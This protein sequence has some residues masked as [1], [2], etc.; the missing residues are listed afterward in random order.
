[1]RRLW[2]IFLLLFSIC[3][4]GRAQVL[5]TEGNDFWLAFL[6]NHQPGELAL[7]ISGNQ[8]TTGSVVSSDSSWSQTFSVV[9]GS[10]TRIVVPST[11]M[12]GDRLSGSEN[13]RIIYGGEIES[14][15][16]FHVTT[17]ANVS[18]YA[19]NYLSA[20]YDITNVLPTATLGQ[21]YVL[22]TVPQTVRSDYED[23]SLH[24]VFG[25]V[26]TEDSTEV[27]FEVVY[28][29]SMV[30][31][32]LPYSWMLNKG[33]TYLYIHRADFSNTKVW[34]EGCKR[35]AV[36]EGHECAYV[37]ISCSACDHLVEQ[38]VPTMYWGR[39]FGL[40]TTKYRTSDNFKVTAM[41]DSTVVTYE[42]ESFVL[43]ALESRT[44]NIIRP[45]ASAGF[46]LEGSKPISVILYLKGGYCAGRLGDPS[47]AVIHP[48]EQQF[49]S[50][51][52]PA[53]NTGRVNTHC[54]NIVTRKI[55]AGNVFLDGT[56]I[57]T[58]LFSPLSG[59]DDYVYTRLDVSHGSHTLT[60]TF[61][62]FVAHEYGLGDVES[63]A[64]ALGTSL[65]PIN[66]QSFLND[67]SFS[68]YDSTNNVFCLGD[69]FRFRAEVVDEYNT[70]IVWNFGDGDTATGLSINHTYLH[71]GDYTVTV[72]YSHY[73]DCYQPTI[74]THTL[75]VHVIDQQIS[76]TDTVVCDTAC[77]WNDHYYY[78][79]GSYSVTIPTGEVCD[80]LAKLNIESMHL[81]PRCSVSYEYDCD[82]HVCHLLA[83]GTGDY[84]RWSSVPH[85]PEL[86]GHE[87]DSLLDVTPS[88]LR[89]YSLYMAYSNDVLCSSDTTVYIPVIDVFRALI[90][91]NPLN[92]DFDHTT[93][94]LADVSP[95]AADRVWYV[96]GS[97][98]S[99]S[100]K[101]EYD[102]PVSR[103]SVVVTLA[104]TSKYDCRDTAQLAIHLVTDGIYIPNII[105]PS[106]RDNNYFQVVGSSL[107]DGEIWIFDRRGAQVWHSN[108]IH[109][110]WDATY[111]GS[112]L[113]QGAYVYTLRYRQASEPDV[114][115]SKTGTVTVVR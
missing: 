8:S 28:E 86:S 48:I 4:M 63:Y 91:A 47:S 5:T 21:Q 36:F 7:L 3:D 88:T 34:T 19:A 93:V 22:Q 51:T 87:G 44:L 69:T 82:A 101:V 53:Y 81:P 37:P 42:N 92:V 97:E 10:V 90:S 73:N 41:Y 107:L 100:Q 12:L 55:Y 76:V 71:P 64:Y 72:N 79:T 109:D 77:L 18:L 52:F 9:P 59:N 50:I 94:T 103:D 60:S 61:G 112:P 106:R 62:G 14:N 85:N 49:S 96:D 31:N 68:M 38:A 32:Q 115:L 15:K 33:E 98:I 75:L 74:Y 95:D 56:I 46:Y 43:N 39:R 84:L 57:D 110:R 1:M 40:T 114:W 16:G 111:N 65:D 113:P 102:Y 23:E 11:Y 26:A 17:E 6:P 20:S 108:D 83:S 66:P 58:A 27:F 24:S 105:T 89:K 70:D 13:D 104:A 35:V 45:S 78:S 30:H 80:S 2:I 67:R 29:D 54:I 99:R 25:V